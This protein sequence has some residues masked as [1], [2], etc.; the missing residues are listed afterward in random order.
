MKKISMSDYTN[1]AM[2]YAS[3]S[4]HRQRF[5]QAFMNYFYSNTTIVDPNLFYCEDRNDAVDMIFDSY[6]NLECV[7]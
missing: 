3:G 7:S 2:G 5:G 4:F 1:F 6:I